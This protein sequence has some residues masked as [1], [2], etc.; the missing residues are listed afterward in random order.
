MER[1]TKE[2][3]LNDSNMRVNAM[4]QFTFYHTES[5]KTFSVTSHE[6]TTERQAGWR[7]RQK[8]TSQ[9]SSVKQGLANDSSC[10]LT[11]IL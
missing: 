3:M 7:I 2:H 11:F 4:Q 8:T 1:F 6:D 10:S 5:T 9:C